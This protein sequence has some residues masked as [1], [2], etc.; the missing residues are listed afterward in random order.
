M[1]ET[2]ESGCVHISVRF[3]EKAYGRLLD[4]KAKEK[5]HMSLN[6]IVVE[7]CMAMIASHPAEKRMENGQGCNEGDE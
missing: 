4:Y 5:P 1:M 6:A 7:A 2:K 3:P